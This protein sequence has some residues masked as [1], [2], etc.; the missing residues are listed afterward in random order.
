MNKTPGGDIFNGMNDS[1]GKEEDYGH[2]DED[3]DKNDEIEDLNKPM[4]PG[5]DDQ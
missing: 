1:N 2:E 3:E 4:H 5:L